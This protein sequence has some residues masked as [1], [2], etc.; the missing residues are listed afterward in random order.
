MVGLV[1]EL[2]VEVNSRYT[3]AARMAHPRCPAEQFQ[4]ATESSSRQNSILEG[5]IWLTN[6]SCADLGESFTPPPKRK[7]K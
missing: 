1:L 2:A 5:Q 3:A 7:G 6:H 4:E